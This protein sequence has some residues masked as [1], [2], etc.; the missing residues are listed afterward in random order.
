MTA[1]SVNPL[2]PMVP[3]C[4]LPA[5]ETELTDAEI[6]ARY[7]PLME[8]AHRA[9]REDPSYIVQMVEASATLRQKR[10]ARRTA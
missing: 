1:A 5:A 7:G 9:F 8:D 2:A 4:A 10:L 3:I 6:L